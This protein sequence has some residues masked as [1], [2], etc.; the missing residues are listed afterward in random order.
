[1]GQQSQRHQVVAI[2]VAVPAQREFEAKSRPR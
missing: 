1:M 2:V